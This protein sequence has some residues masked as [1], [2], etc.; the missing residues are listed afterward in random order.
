MSA[1]S[2]RIRILGNEL[3]NRLGLSVGATPTIGDQLAEVFNLVA[4][5]IFE[6]EQSKKQ[7]PALELAGIFM[8]PTSGAEIWGA[9]EEAILLAEHTPDKIICFVF[10]GTPVEVWKGITAREAVNS[11]VERRLK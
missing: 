10:N 1:R 7:L 5:H 4:D 3:R 2:D 8:R 11:Y 9:C 6:K